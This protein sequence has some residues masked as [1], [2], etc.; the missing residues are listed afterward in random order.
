MNA[1]DAFTTLLMAGA[2]GAIGLGLRAARPRLDDRGLVPK[3]AGMFIIA[4]V[5]AFAQVV[6]GHL[7]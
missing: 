3:V 2:L 1:M 7:V 5:L 4:A 6:F